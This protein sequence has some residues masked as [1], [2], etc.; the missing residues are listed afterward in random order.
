MPGKQP[1]PGQ[2]SHEVKVL[3]VVLSALQSLKDPEARRRIV[4]YVLQAL[5]VP[6]TGRP[7]MPVASVLMP[8]S[9]VQPSATSPRLIDIRTFKEQK[10]PRNAIEM[11]T[12][13]AYYLAELAPTQE[14]RVTISTADINRFFRQAGF[15]LPTQPRLTLFHAKAAGYLDLAERGQYKLSPVG[16]NL[17][18]HTLPADSE[19]GS[20][21]RAPRRGRRPRKGSRKQ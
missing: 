10:K 8:E 15:P 17:I 6:E 2:L 11:A 13:L 14:R 21:P 7:R 5:S 4:D 9:S 12:L 19:S 1:R 18:A 3:N 16:Y 20:A